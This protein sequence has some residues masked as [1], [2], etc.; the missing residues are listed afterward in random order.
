MPKTNEEEEIKHQFNIKVAK[1]LR[2]LQQ[3]QDTGQYKCAEIE[4]SL[5]AELF[6]S[7]ITEKDKE[8]QKAREEERREVYDNLYNDLL[9]IEAISAQKKIDGDDEFSE[10][11]WYN[12]GYFEAVDDIA[13]HVSTYKD[14]ITPPTN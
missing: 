10:E 11:Y 7:V 8:L 3:I 6:D 12:R 2:Y 5:L 9:R 4:L 1:L 13:K 14:A